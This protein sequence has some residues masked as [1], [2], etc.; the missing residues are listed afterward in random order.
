MLSTPGDTMTVG[1]V[2]LCS[3][4]TQIAFNLWAAR[5]ARRS[6]RRASAST[7]EEKDPPASESRLR[8]LEADVVSL[9]SS[10]E[11]VA[12]DLRRLNSRAG[13]RELRSRQD[14]SDAPPTGAGKAE[15]YRHYGI[16]GK[17]PR[18]IAATQ[19]GMLGRED[20]NH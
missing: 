17:S 18:D 6:S 14:A 16:A 2:L 9:S 15:L 19:L 3:L 10:F 4:I 5:R 13:M 7:P 12:K 11:R 20:T 1:L 8:E